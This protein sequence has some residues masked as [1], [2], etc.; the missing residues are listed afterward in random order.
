MKRAGWREFALRAHNKSNK[1]QDNMPTGI[2]DALEGHTSATVQLVT[3][4][5]ACVEATLDNVT[6]ADGS[7]FKAKAR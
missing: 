7:Q 4:D 2:A 3:S 1:N 6:K 5:A